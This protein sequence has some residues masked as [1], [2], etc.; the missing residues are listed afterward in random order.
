V[1]GAVVAEITTAGVRDLWHL[2]NEFK[3]TKLW[4]AVG[5]WWAE[6]RLIRCELDLVRVV[7]EERL[8]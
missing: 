3:F 8:E 1:F 5:D 4:S 6:H 2:C 7:L